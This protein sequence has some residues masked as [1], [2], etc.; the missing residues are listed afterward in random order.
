MPILLLDELVVVGAS[1]ELTRKLVFEQ[2]HQP[3]SEVVHAL[4]AE[5]L[6]AANGVNGLYK[7]DLCEGAS[8]A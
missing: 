8:A 4:C 3:G 7:P 6:V 5:L 2:C 1:A